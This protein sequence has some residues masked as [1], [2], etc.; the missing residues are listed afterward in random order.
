MSSSSENPHPITSRFSDIGTTPTRLL[1]TVMLLPLIDGIFAA[2]VVAG[3]IDTIIGAAQ[4]GVLVF[5]GS[6][7]AAVILSDFKADMKQNL[8]SVTYVTILL[9]LGAI[10]TAILSPVITELINTQLFERFAAIVILS[11]AAKT[12]SAYIGEKLPRPSAIILLGFVASITPKNPFELAISIDGTLI[13]HAIIAAL[14]GSFFAYSVVLLRSHLVQH[15]NIERFRFGSAVALGLIS[16][17]ILGLTPMSAPL[18]VLGI[19]TLLS[20]DLTKETEDN[21]NAE[22]HIHTSQTSE[23]VEEKDV[24]DEKYKTTPK[25][26]NY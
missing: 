1:A 10:I 19:T 14:A 4:I 12:A 11:I 13:S 16:V 5:G 9:V 18:A 25:G 21:T 3:A 20:L 15:L 22:K 26:P 7:T 23:N 17:A 24:P 8:K 6:A 2:L